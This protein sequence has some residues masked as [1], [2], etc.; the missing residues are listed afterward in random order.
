MG[1]MDQ[2]CK[3]LKVIYT[4]PKAFIKING[5]LS[6]TVNIQRGIRQGCPLSCLIFIICTEFMSLYLKQNAHDWN[7]KRK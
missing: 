2:F 3:W 5:F 4:D 6:E 1:F 7:L